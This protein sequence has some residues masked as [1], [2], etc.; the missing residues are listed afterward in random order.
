M[1]RQGAYDYVLDIH[2]SRADVG[3]FLLAAQLDGPVRDV[4]A[5]SGFERL[6]IMPPHIADCSLIGQV[7]QA[8]SIEYDRR[9][10]STKR[11]LQELTTL[12]D[13]LL[14]HRFVQK[15]REVFYVSGKIPLQSTLDYDAKNFELSEQGF[16]PVIFS[17]NSSYTEY[18]G[19]AAHRRD[20][21][22]A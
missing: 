13:N 16:Y 2:T 19:F 10:A 1:I 8:V 20:V 9:L 6:A 11:T 4:L 22:V 18:R 15:P 3:R 7:T 21:I 5:A 14:S 12:L 17:R